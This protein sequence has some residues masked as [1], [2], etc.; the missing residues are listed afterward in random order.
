M[1]RKIAK[2][3]LKLH[4]R[5]IEGSPWTGHPCQ[6]GQG[7]LT[8]ARFCPWLS[9][10]MHH[11]MVSLNVTASDGVIYTKG[12]VVKL[13]FLDIIHPSPPLANKG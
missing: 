1:L 13:N 9:L 5:E 12:V 10:L 7:H 4:Y 3:D 6:G 8:C 11:P 2:L